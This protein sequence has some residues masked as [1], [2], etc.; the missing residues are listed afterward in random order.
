MPPYADEKE[1]RALRRR[2][3]PK[4]RQ[5]EPQKYGIKD[6]TQEI[7]RIK[8]RLNDIPKS[9]KLDSIYTTYKNACDSSIKLLTS[10]A[11]AH[12]IG[13]IDDKIVDAIYRKYQ[14]SAPS[15][16]GLIQDGDIRKSENTIQA[17]INA[18]NTLSK[19]PELNFSSM[20]KVHVSVYNIG[21]SLDNF[22]VRRG[23]PTKQAIPSA[24]KTNNKGHTR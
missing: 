6:I 22:V 9:D 7:Q 19:S 11:D 21:K 2:Q 13:K 1:L 24:Q 5:P 10:V 23:Q 20:E 3:A 4:S 15:S 16:K 12:N 8:G 18:I 17:N 14:P